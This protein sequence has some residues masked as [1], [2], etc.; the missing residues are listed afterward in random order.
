MKTSGGLELDTASVKPA[1]S[2]ANDR[3]LRGDRTHAVGN[4]NGSKTHLTVTSLHLV[5]LFSTDLRYVEN[6]RTQVLSAI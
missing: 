5:Q 1:S 6:Q 3:T 4:Q 2:T